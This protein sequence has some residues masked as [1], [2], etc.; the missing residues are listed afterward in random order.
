V[1]VLLITMWPMTAPRFDPLEEARRQW[2]VH[3]LDEPL[4]MTVATSIIHANQVVTTTVDRA[5][6]PLGL[7]FARFEV[8]TLL[9]FSRAGAL[10]ITKIGERLL[11]HPTGVTRLVDKLEAEGYVE[12]RVNPADRRGTLVHLNE[13]GRTLARTAVKALGEVRFGANLVD[14]DLER[15][16]SLL[17]VLRQAAPDR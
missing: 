11:V 8:L 5:L 13:A 2:E 12:R 9:S 7:T 16:V 4:A 6:R 1:A 3:G 14:A 15:L 10:P 17:G